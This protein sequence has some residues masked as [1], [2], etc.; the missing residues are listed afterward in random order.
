VGVNKVV[1]RP[2]V[3][4]GIVVIRQV[5]NLSASFDHRIVDG[6][7]AATFVQGLR[8]CLEAPATMFVD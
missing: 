7:R 1:E 4:D 5:M 8:A 2:V 3:R 6:L